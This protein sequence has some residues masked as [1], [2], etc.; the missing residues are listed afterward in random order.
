[1]EICRQSHS[2]YKAISRNLCFF[3]ISFQ[4]MLILVSFLVILFVFCSSLWWRKRS[5]L[6]S[7]I[8]LL[9][10]LFST[11]Y[12]M[13]F[14]TTIDDKLNSD[15]TSKELILTALLWKQLP[16][17]PPWK[18]YVRDKELNIF[19]CCMEMFLEL[20]K[21]LVLSIYISFDRIIILNSLYRWISIDPNWKL[22]NVI[23]QKN[24]E[25]KFEVSSHGRYP[26]MKIAWWP[27]RKKASSNFILCIVILSFILDMHLCYFMCNAIF[28]INKIV[29]KKKYKKKCK[30]CVCVPKYCLL[31]F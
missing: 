1:M 18:E 19:C 20:L 6:L 2:R 3:C 10:I 17:K 15:L 26:N 8:W 4:E 30:L 31:G 9:F 24:N 22:T 21:I 29:A 12:I 5:Y 28:Y 14:T 7:M 16:W 11:S 27:L 23:Q 13:R 25:E